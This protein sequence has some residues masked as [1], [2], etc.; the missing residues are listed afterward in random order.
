MPYSWVISIV[1][2][3]YKKGIKI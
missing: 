3:Y 1:S 2:L